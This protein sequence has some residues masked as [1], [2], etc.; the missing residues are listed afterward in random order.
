MPADRVE[1]G[2]LATVLN[3]V[4][5]RYSAGDAAGAMR[6]CTALLERKPNDAAALNM[7][8]G[9]LLAQGR[10][11]AALPSLHD[12]INAD[13]A[14]AAAH[15]N[16]R[17]AYE[18]SGR[19]A[20]CTAYFTRFIASHPRSAP[21]H[22]HLGLALSS[23]G[24]HER[25]AQALVV[26]VEM[27]PDNANAWHALGVAYGALGR[28]DEAL[29]AFN[30]ALALHAHYWQ[31][32]NN[33]ANLLKARGAAAQAWSHYQQAL[34]QVP[35]SP[36]VLTNAAN[37]LRALGN[38]EAA[39]E[40]YRRV[41]E[42]DERY[43]PARCNYAVLLQN[44][45][46]IEAA[47]E[48]LN[49]ILRYDPQYAE[50]QAYIAMIELLRGDMHGGAERYEWRR[51]IPAW[52]SLAPPGERSEWRREPLADKTVLVYTEQG[53]GDCIQFIRFAIDLRARGACVVFRGHEPMRG[54]ISSVPGVA[55]FNGA[56]EAP[57][58][59]D[60]HVPVMSLMHRLGVSL[61]NVPTPIPYVSAE[62]CKVEACCVQ[63]GG[64]GL[65][66]VGLAWAGSPTHSNDRY[67]SMR[68]ELLAP[69]LAERRCRFISLQ[70]GAR[71]ADI[72]RAGL[73]SK[74]EDL[75]CLQ[76]SLT[77]TAALMECLD[78]VITVD[79]AV[80]HLA[81]ALGRPVWVMLARVPD[82]RWMLER[83]DSP[84]YPSMRLFRQTRPGDWQTV[85]TAV[86]DALTVHTDRYEFGSGE[87]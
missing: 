48:Q 1:D 82:W 34:A 69:L 32:H 7:H 8:G 43:S 11:E 37:C 54:L 35:H 84:W 9:L 44:L 29:D 3:E 77:D 33:L 55:A 72:T 67:R 57:P 10:N 73:E 30:R 12:A 21:A 79:T 16:L 19:L 87:R 65:L 81:G 31:A 38:D 5:A 61:D 6:L 47:T 50:A 14:L 83:T 42:L 28:E 60:Y 39:A 15:N 64:G 25:A 27:E 36:E 45:G 13:P 78:L 20:E 68:L 46:A 23:A 22:H 51:R 71:A 58:P 2:A 59:H 63:L 53:L 66:R 76:R 56:G 75:S 62:P 70:I 26:A 85:V 49:H 52:R 40:H 80:A 24:E 18:R 86:R 4:T 17:I 74:L 41:I